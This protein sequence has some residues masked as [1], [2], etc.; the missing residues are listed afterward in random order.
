MLQ[1]RVLVKELVSKTI[2][3]GKLIV[4]DSVTKNLSRGRIIA[5]DEGKLRIGDIVLFDNRSSM[6]I[7]FKTSEYL[8]VH[9]NQII[10]VV[11][12]KSKQRKA[13]V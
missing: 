3:V 8:I 7:T 4:P 13:S 5:V 10:A 11:K 6:P 2:P 12:R 1:Q 9:E